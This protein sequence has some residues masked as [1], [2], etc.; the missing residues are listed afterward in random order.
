MRSV[1]IALFVSSLAFA[2]P[3]SY[4]S[5]PLNA[6]GVKPQLAAANL[7]EMM[8]ELTAKDTTH[9][10]YIKQSVWFKR[11]SIEM[12]FTVDSISGR[13]D[14]RQAL[15]R[16]GAYCNGILDTTFSKWF[17]YT[18]KI[19][20]PQ[21]GLVYPRVDSL[22]YQTTCGLSNPNFTLLISMDKVLGDPTIQ[23]GINQR[24]V[25]RF[26]YMEKKPQSWRKYVDS[27]RL[28]P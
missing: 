2:Q 21:F 3:K 13:G 11:D 4:V 10:V 15:I 7:Y 16:F 27:L 24:P 1:I 6:W 28:A 8:W 25:L 20:D 5:P 23:G 17:A 22:N 14:K 19:L 12:S 9:P 18:V 26:R